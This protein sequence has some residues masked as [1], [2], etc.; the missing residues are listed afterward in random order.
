MT[1][2][3]GF[4]SSQ[5]NSLEINRGIMGNGH[6]V[7][8]ISPF[9]ILADPVERLVQ[10]H[11]VREFGRHDHIGIRQCHDIGGNIADGRQNMIDSLYTERDILAFQ[12]I[13][14]IDSH[15]IIQAV[16]CGD[17]GI[18]FARLPILKV[19]GPIRV[20]AVFHADCDIDLIVLEFACDNRFLRQLDIRSPERKRRA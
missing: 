15:E 18:V 10:S 4:V 1:G 8:I 12:T 20:H 9:A 5:I 14:R 11:I 17:K 13:F 19:G 3:F 6:T 2:D 16:I 7:H